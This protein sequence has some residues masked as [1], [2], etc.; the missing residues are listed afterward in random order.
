MLDSRPV[1]SVGFLLS[2]EGTYQRMG[3]SALQGLQDAL[4]EINAQTWRDTRLQATCIDP[5]GEHAGY[6][7]GI[8]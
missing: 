6:R 7:R 2:T 3:R 1:V 8:E 4:Q 5:R